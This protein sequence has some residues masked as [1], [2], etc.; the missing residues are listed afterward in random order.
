ME[1]LDL[2]LERL[3]ALEELLETMKLGQKEILTF[4]EACCFLG[5]SRSNL[6]KLTSTKMIPHFCPNG[7]MLYFN[8]KELTAWLQ[9]NRQR[10]FS[11]LEV[12]KALG[13]LSKS[14]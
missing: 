5:M 7:K 2:I 3:T 8:R 10:S 9:Q 1:K 12:D 13:L 14:A 11:E 4:K 6:Y